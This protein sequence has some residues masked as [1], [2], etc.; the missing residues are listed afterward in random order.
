M[1][2]KTVKFQISGMTCGGCAHT[3]ERS[4]R[5]KNGLVEGKV[6]YK[7]KAGE[8]TFDAE[9]MTKEEIIAAINATGHYKVEGE[10]TEN[11]DGDSKQYDLIIIGGGSAAFAAAIRA[12]ELGLTIMMVN[13]GLPVGGTCVNVGCV[14]SKNLIRAAGSL[15]KASVSPFRGI[16]LQQPKVDF[17]EIISQKRELISELRQ[18]KYKDILERLEN[19]HYVKG[20]AV[21]SGTKTILVNGRDTYKGLKF[22]IASGAST[23][24]LPVE[25]LDKVPY[26]TNRTLFEEESLPESLIVMGG[27]YIALE[28][29]QTWQRMGTKVTILQRS[30]HVLSKQTEEVAEEITMH[31]RNDGLEIVTGLDFK[32]VTEEHGRIQVHAGQNGENKTFVADRLLVSTGIRPNT[33]GLGAEIAGLELTGSGHIKVNN[34]LETNLPNVFAAGDCINTPAYVYTAAY[35]GK[36]AVE[37]AFTGAN[38]ETDYTGMP[39]VV[40]TDPEVAG[41][42]L[43]E[44]EAAALG[45]PFE[46]SVV[47]LSEVPRSL[48]AL[49]TRGFIKLIRNPGNDRLL[50]ARI[51]APGGSELTMELSLAIKYGI[52]VKELAQSFHAYLTLS[53]AV[54]LAAIG[55]EKDIKTLSCCAV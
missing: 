20:M 29:A 23:K 11:T 30:S 42:G 54:K 45:L 52:P 49:D 8:F 5:G 38:R 21:F 6:S 16:H 28:I 55:F 27:G 41:V 36:L 17:K 51:V 2:T 40:F 14:P 32:Q 44:K 46:V 13:D 18:K 7:D 12:E 1:E 26:F 39:W 22:L 43:D 10:I 34:R 48:A 3:V 25:G 19:V 50:G 35:E 37:N 4:V 31:L 33:S 47:E 53:E 24:I 9:K 15:H